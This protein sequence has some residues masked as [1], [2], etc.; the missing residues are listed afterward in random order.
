[1]WTEKLSRMNLLNRNQYILGLKRNSF[2]RHIDFMQPFC[3]QPQNYASDFYHTQSQSSLFADQI[4]QLRIVSGQTKLNNRFLSSN[5]S[6]SDS[7]KS[8]PASDAPELVI[9]RS[10][11]DVVEAQLNRPV[12]KNSLSKKLIGELEDFVASVRNDKKI[13]CVIFRSV[14]PGVFCAG[15]DLKER[16]KMHIDEVAPFVCRLR[17]AFDDVSNLSVPVI[18]ALDGVA[19][20][21]G[22]ELALACDFR[23]ASSTTKLGLVETKLGIIPGA[24][25]TQ[26][27]PRLIGI[28]KAK[29][30]IYTGRVLTGEQAS[31]IGLVNEAVAQN[32]EGNA[33]YEHALRFAKEI[34]K[35]GPVAVKMAKL[36]IDGGIEI[37]IQAALRLEE[38]CYSAVIPTKDRIEGLN[39]FKEKR[40]PNYTGE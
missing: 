5:S 32:D 8:T 22:L 33:A 15:A 21:G 12:G 23:F 16:A 26:R 38:S 29:E 18:A 9:V 6:H 4:K 20:G 3:L 19:L 35:N 30:L 37:D 13:R 17:K 39:A 2:K 28:S 31:E 24:G 1:M 40:T 34:A 11:N 36:S 7:S 25:G 27:L 10:D 14:V